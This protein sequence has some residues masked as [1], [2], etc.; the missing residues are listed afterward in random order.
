MISAKL[1]KK[2]K[3]VELGYTE[4]PEAETFD[5]YQKWVE[6]D[7]QG[8]LKYLSDE[9][10]DKRKSLKEI[11][12]EF[13][14]ALVLLFDYSSDKKLLNQLHG[15]LKFGSYAFGFEGEDYHYW[16][17]RALNEIARELKQE[18]FKIC[19]DTAPVLERDLA[20]RAGLGWV[21]KNSML[22]H[23]RHGSYVMIGS[24]L[25]SQKLEIETKAIEPDHCGTC[26]ACLDS[27]PTDAILDNR[28]INARQCI[29]TYTIELFKE[30][31]N[32]V[33]EGYPDNNSH[34]FGCDICQEVCPWNSKPLSRADIPELNDKQKL[35]H[36]FFLNKSPK[37]VEE[38]L[39]QMSNREYKKI[40][41]GTSFERTGR[42]GI[43]KNLDKILKS[44]S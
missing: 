13:Q 10:K 21:G 5:I 12:P 38:E 22:I 34:F 3:I 42:L 29:S 19:V 23:K 44:T 2:F 24:L 17:D 36:E 25:L 11:F 27:C 18:N 26:T 43:L 6:E 20:K 8:P 41:K 1:L 40:F 7:Y 28:T 30:D 4:Q 37:E 32:A 15:D 9:R 33:P 16:I 14:S 39:N 31:Q 35:I